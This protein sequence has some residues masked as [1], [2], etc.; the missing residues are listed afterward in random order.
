M[1]TAGVLLLLAALAGCESHNVSEF[2]AKVAQDKYPIKEDASPQCIESAKKAKKWCVS[3]V[4]VNSDVTWQREC[5]LAQWEYND[6][7]LG[8]GRGPVTN[9]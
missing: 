7:C 1:R 5:M 4:N 3:T 2:D 8:R 9:F 6:F